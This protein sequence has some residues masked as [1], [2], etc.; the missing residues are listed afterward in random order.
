MVSERQQAVEFLTEDHARL[1]EEAEQL[2]NR[3]NK[4]KARVRALESDSATHKQQLKVLVEKTESDDI[5][6]EA[7]Q[8][9]MQSLRQSNEDM[10]KKLAQQQQQLSQTTTLRTMRMNENGTG[11]I[12]AITTQE[13]NEHEILRLKRLCKQQV[14]YLF[15]L[16]FFLFFLLFLLIRLLK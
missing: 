5:L 13:G 8:E 15:L 2:K 14:V 9:E 12:P 6:I 10:K 7:L 3:V 4:Y 11:M 1:T 16:F